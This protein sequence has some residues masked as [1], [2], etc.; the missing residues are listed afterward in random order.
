[1]SADIVSLHGAPIKG[2]VEPETRTRVVRMLTDALERAKAGK[3]SG[4]RIVEIDE[5][6]VPQGAKAGDISFAMLGVMVSMT[7]DLERGLDRLMPF[8]T[9]VADAPDGPPSSD[10]E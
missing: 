9:E 5:N 3:I 10:D 7:A 6:N 2:Y 1:M 4:I 8:E